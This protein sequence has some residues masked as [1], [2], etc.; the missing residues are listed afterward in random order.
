MAGKNK[1]A[2]K[3]PQK[4]SLAA[5]CEL[6]RLRHKKADDDYQRVRKRFFDGKATQLELD[7]ATN[8]RKE[9][10]RDYEE[11]IRKLAKAKLSE[12]RNDSSNGYN[13]SMQKK[14]NMPKVSKSQRP[15]PFAGADDIYA[16]KNK[17]AVTRTKHVKAKRGFTKTTQT[18]YYE[19]N[20]SNKKLLKAAQGDTVRVGRKGTGFKKI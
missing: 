7:N 6:A 11:S 10:M 3:L 8:K 20:Y 18:K 4:S 9:S 17:I 15:N 16:T 19:Q 2:G 14:Q 12:C 13:E 5:E 1:T